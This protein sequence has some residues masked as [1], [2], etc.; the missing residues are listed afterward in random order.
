MDRFFFTKIIQNCT[1][2]HGYRAHS[3]FLKI[4]D[5]YSCDMYIHTSVQI[6]SAL[7]YKKLSFAMYRQPGQ[8]GT[9][10]VKISP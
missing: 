8:V 9:F 1:S 3:D 6:S 2:K 10:F 4:A 5:F 7:V